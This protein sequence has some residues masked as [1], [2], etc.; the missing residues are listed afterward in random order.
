[1]KVTREAHPHLDVWREDDTRAEVE[2]VERRAP[3]RDLLEFRRI[4]EDNFTILS[5]IPQPA[6]LVGASSTRR[7]DPVY[8]GAG[9]ASLESKE[10]QASFGDPNSEMRRQLRT[11]IHD[12]VERITD[13]RSFR[14][15]ELKAALVDSAL[16]PVT[17]ET[18]DGPKCIKREV[19]SGPHGD[20][21]RFVTRALSTL[22]NDT[23]LHEFIVPGVS[24]LDTPVQAGSPITRGEAAARFVTASQRHWWTSAALEVALNSIA[25]HENQIVSHAEE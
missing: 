9:P 16:G 7:T 2:H 13:G 15:I 11:A 14:P 8:M 1:M 5:K 21:K 19:L 18:P 23:V 17:L 10:A 25:E 3:L 4:D 12:A 24:A 22:V 20:T 6:A